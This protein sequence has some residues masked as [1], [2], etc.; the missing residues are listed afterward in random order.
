MKDLGINLE[1]PFPTSNE[2]SEIKS[3]YDYCKSYSGQALTWYQNSKKNKR[4]WALSIRFLSVF[5]VSI[6]GILPIVNQMLPLTQ[7]GVVSI[8]IALSAAL[9][10][11]DKYFGFSSAWMRFV[12]ADRNIMKT[13]NEFSHDWLREIVN[14]TDSPL[15]IDKKYALINLSKTFVSNI[16][17]IISE[18]TNAWIAEFQ[19]NLKQLDESITK[20]KESIKVNGALNITIKSI[21][22]DKETWLLYLDDNLI[23]EYNSKTAVINSIIPGIHS[24]KVQVNKTGGESAEK[25]CEIGSGVI[26]EMVI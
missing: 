20:M 22:I 21:E 15:T 26:T 9:I 2:D 25:L 13:L 11:L 1:K 12:E 14:N 10:A 7:P 23:K 16:D 4:R 24:I 8:L 19:S 5:F 17:R 6:A 3:L 18:E